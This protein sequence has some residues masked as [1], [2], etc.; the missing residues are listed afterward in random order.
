M[1]QPHVAVIGAGMGGLAA[2]VD[3]A[4]RG[5]RVSIFERGAGPGG[6]MRQV[7]GI[8]AGP[9]VF[10][11][12]WIFESLFADAGARLDDCLSLAPARTLARHGWL[13]GSRLDLHADIDDSADAIEAFSDRENADGYRAFCARSRAIFSAL[14]NSF[15]ESSRPNVASLISRMGPKHIPTMLRTSPATSLWKALGEHFTD[16]RLRQLF[17]RYATYVGSSP[18]LTPAT[19]ML[20]AHVEQ[21]GVWLVDGGMVAV[22]HA[23]TR[24]AQANGAEFHFDA[25]VEAIHVERDR[26]GGL[27]LNDGSL[28]TADAVVFNGDVN[29]LASGALGAEA[30][31]A[32]RHGAPVTAAKR[33]LSA[34]TW[35]TRARPSG[36]E[37]D[38]HNVFFGDDYH[39]EFDAIFE[40]RDM[41]TR[42]TV[43]LCA[44]DRGAHGTGAQDYE[45]MLLLI[46]A[47]ADGDK[48]AFGEDTVT[49]MQA[50]AEAV[51]SACGLTLEHATSD[52]TTPNSFNTLFPCTGGALYGQATH[53]MF[54]SFQRAAAATKL[55][56]LFVA[57]G[58][59]HPGAGIP[60]ATMSGRLAANAVATALSLHP[61]AARQ[62]AM[63]G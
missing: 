15:I 4:A 10:T 54:A 11:M 51:M 37:L 20:I 61:T 38:H 32:V 35:C 53:G 9:T 59:A 39:D 40:R 7:N 36:F 55:P 3:L 34:I 17:G 14:Q 6:K 2:A 5:A 43:Y 49:T 27:V 21:E 19:L 42:P 24:L 31:T 16:P 44:Q 58:S 23:L 22:A 25:H 48:R 45:R 18:M 1:R 8:D 12:R 63:G 28:V 29:A 13:D 62:R 41:T 50:R 33:S 26:A 47:P 60:M 46:N 57:G 52:V 56:G 30:R